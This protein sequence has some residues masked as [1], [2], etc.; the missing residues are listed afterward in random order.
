MRSPTSIVAGKEITEAVR[1]RRSLASSLLYA[2]MGPTIVGLL[3]FTRTSAA[4]ESKTLLALSSLFL[5]LSTFA[6]GM[7]IAMDTLAGERERKS[8]LP[9]VMNPVSKLQLIA[10]KWICIGVFSVVALFLN[11]LAFAI[12]IEHVL[13]AR[14]VELAQLPLVACLLLAKVPLAMLAAA[15]ELAIST[16]CRSVK[17]AH[18]WLAFLVFVPVGLGMFLAFHPNVFGEWSY[19]VPVLG[20]QVLLSSLAAGEIPSMSHVFVLCVVSIVG[21]ISLLRF[22]SKLLQRDDVLYGN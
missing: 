22:T 21:T 2:L 9:L 15:A 18:T 8:L 3:T 19:A 7:N 14:F 11:F 16:I 5:L 1:D 13:P 20:Q 4:T 10:G 17:E 12:I 6:G